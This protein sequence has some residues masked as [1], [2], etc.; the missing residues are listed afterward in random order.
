[1]LAAAEISCLLLVEAFDGGEELLRAADRLHLEGIVSNC[2]NLPYRSGPCRDW[3]KIKTEA[4]RAA[5]WDRWRL[6]EKR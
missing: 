5:N 6:F 4:W 1:M 2:R 3:R